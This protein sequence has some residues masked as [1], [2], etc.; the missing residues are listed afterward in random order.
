MQSNLGT[1]FEFA[2][3]P[4]QLNG[5]SRMRGLL[6]NQFE[7]FFVSA[8]ILTP[9]RQGRAESFDRYF[10]RVGA[11]FRPVLGRAN[12]SHLG[13]EFPRQACQDAQNSLSRKARIEG[14]V[15]SGSVICE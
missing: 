3:A 14:N 12:V 9:P 13:G 2:V 5:A 4:S 7:S 11:S 6:V 8:D 10:G 15:P 1:G